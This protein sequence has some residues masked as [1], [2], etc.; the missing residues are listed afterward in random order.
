MRYSYHFH[1]P[2]HAWEV[3]MSVLEDHPFFAHHHPP[4]YEDVFEIR[5]G[6]HFGKDKMHKGGHAMRNDEFPGKFRFG[7]GGRGGR[8]PHP[9]H[10]PYAFGLRGHHG[11][12][13]F[14]PHRHGHGH[15]HNYDPDHESEHAFNPW[16]KHDRSGPSH[17]GFHHKRGGPGPHAHSRGKFHRGGLGHGRGPVNRHGKGKGFHHVNS[18]HHMHPLMRAHRHYSPETASFTPPVD[19]FVTATQTVVHASLPGAQKSDVSVGYDAS[20]SMLRIAGVVHR[21][22]VD[23]E[24]HRA[25][26]VGERGRH[27]GVF[28]REIPVSHEV[29]VDGVQARLED[30]VLKVVLPRV[31]G[32]EVLNGSE[33]EVEMVNADRELS[34]PTGSHTE[35]ED[36]EEH[37]GEDEKVEKEFVKVDIQ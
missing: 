18:L 37:E 33:V 36:E 21:P 28:E 20:R 34:T 6:K 27:L 17:P 10:H 23:E 16:T 7:F 11:R 29:V 31:E 3:D 8:H 4:R 22:G 15:G 24:M 25:L 14:H 13:K 12:G 19:V 1:Q 30:G 9:H 35:G 5:H 32:E 2:P 26:L